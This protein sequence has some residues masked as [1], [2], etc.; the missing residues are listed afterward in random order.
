[1]PHPPREDALRAFLKVEVDI[2]K[3]LVRLRLHWDKHE[4]RMFSRAKNITDEELTSWDLANDLE[5]VRSASTAY[6]HI[7]FGKLRI[8]SIVDAYLHVRIHHTPGAGQDNVK[9]HSVLTN[10]VKDSKGNI[11]G[12]DA[13]Q[14]KSARLDF[15][16]E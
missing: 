11:I 5:E 15:F 9:L 7:I 2:K 13:F 4:P 16:N 10:E 6:G 3:E 14:P 8:P 1:M 12:F